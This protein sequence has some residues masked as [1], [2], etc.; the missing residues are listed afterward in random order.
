MKTNTCPD[1]HYPRPNHSTG[2]CPG[3]SDADDAAIEAKR[4]ADMDPYLFLLEAAKESLLPGSMR[5]RDSANAK[6]RRAIKAAEEELK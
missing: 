4:E 3:W 2:T 5:D 1:C 6:L